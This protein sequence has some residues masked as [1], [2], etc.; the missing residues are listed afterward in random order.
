MVSEYNSLIKN[1]TWELI[2]LPADRDPI[3]T[4]WVYKVKYLADGSIDRYKA[5]FVAKGFS[6]QEGIDYD[7]TFAPV[8]KFNNLLVVL[9]IATYEDLELELMDVKTAFLN[10]EIMEDIYVTQPEGFVD[11]KRPHAVCK[12]KKSLYG[13]KQ[14]P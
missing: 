8:A 6:Q 1:K 14:A 7:E 2:D 4:K 9:A 11:S 5:R 10:G 3:N 12:L 13:L